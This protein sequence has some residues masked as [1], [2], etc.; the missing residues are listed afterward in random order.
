VSDLNRFLEAQDEPRSGFVNALAEIRSGRKTSH[1][2]WY[3]FP[4]LT[5]LGSSGMSVRYGLA[6]VTEARAY[7]RHPELRSRLATITA[8]VADHARRGA[9]FD[10]IMGSSIDA[11]KLVSSLTLFADVARQLYDTEPLDAYRDFAAMADEILDRAAKAGYPRC[12]FTLGRLS[13]GTD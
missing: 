9:S 5:G 8:A 4:Q 7:L 3:V 1:W 10:V 6:D 12:S 11:L 13:S 2:I